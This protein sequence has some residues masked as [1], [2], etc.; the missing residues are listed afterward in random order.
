[1]QNI[2]HPRV[3]ANLKRL[4]IYAELT[5]DSKKRRI[6][7]LRDNKLKTMENGVTATYISAFSGYHHGKLFAA[8]NKKRQ[9]RIA[10]EEVQK[11]ILVDP[12]LGELFR[13]QDWKSMITALGTGCTIEALSKEAGLDDG[14]RSI[15]ASVDRGLSTLNRAKSV[16]AKLAR[17]AA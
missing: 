11:F 2:I 12:E 3:P 1:M 5:G 6:K 13:V 9:A 4:K 7:S 10:W 17:R 15:F 14:F 16:K 8:A